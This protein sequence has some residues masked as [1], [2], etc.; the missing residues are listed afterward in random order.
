MWWY[1]SNSLIDRDAQQVK[2]DIHTQVVT[3]YCHD[4]EDFYNNQLP[5][6]WRD[7]V[8]SL[9]AMVDEFFR[10]QMQHAGEGTKMTYQAQCQVPGSLVPDGEDDDD[11][12][13]IGLQLGFVEYV[14]IQG[15]PFG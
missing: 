13:T 12:V 15:D 3:V 4:D 9:Q 1:A 2:D 14:G 7:Q 6:V 5:Q 11:R 8:E 10:T